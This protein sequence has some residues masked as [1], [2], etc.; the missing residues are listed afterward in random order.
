MTLSS[1]GKERID[2]MADDIPMG[3][4]GTLDDISRRGVLASN[5]TDFMTAGAIA[6]RWRNHRGYKG[7]GRT[8]RHGGVRPRADRVVLCPAQGSVIIPV[9]IFAQ[10]GS[11]RGSLFTFRTFSSAGP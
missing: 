9:L 4:I 5:E 10:K 6:E 3:R 1:I 7:R 8:G 2:G 11:P